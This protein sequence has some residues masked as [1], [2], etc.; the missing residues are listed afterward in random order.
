MIK[1]VWFFCAK[2]CLF[3]GNLFTETFKSFRKDIFKE[4][5]V[6]TD[7]SKILYELQNE[8]GNSSL[9]FVLPTV[10]TLW[11]FLSVPFFLN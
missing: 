7:L 11:Y 10:Q 3:I 6:D 2:S 1:A 8:I 5:K 9:Q 4:A